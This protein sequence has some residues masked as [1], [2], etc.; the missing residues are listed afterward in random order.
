M[1][2]RKLAYLLLEAAMVVSFAHCQTATGVNYNN[3]VPAA[4]S[5]ARN[6][7]WQH[8]S[9]SPTVN[10]S[11]YMTDMLGDTGSGGADG[12][13][14]APTSGD[15]AA[16]DYLDA[17]GNWTV[18]PG[19]GGVV[20]GTAIP[21]CTKSG[22]N[23]YVYECDTSPTFTPVAGTMILFTVQDTSGSS[24]TLNVNGNGNQNFYAVGAAISAGEILDQT[25]LLIAY[26][27]INSW[28]ILSPP[29]ILPT[30]GGGTSTNGLVTAN[31]FLGGPTSGYAANVTFR[32]L[33]AAD[34]P[35]LNQSTTGNAA[36]ATALA[37]S[38]TNCSTGY[39]P[40]GINASGTAQGCAA[41]GGGGTGTVTSVAI[42]PPSIISASGSPIT[43]SGTI[44]ETL[45]TQSA[46]IVLAGPSSGS[47]ATPTFRAL[48]SAD[49]PTLNQS[50]TGN[51]ATA[52]A[53]AS[54]P[55]NCSTG[56]APTG[57]NASGTA[58]GCAALN[59]FAPIATVGPTTYT[60][61][62]GVT[63]TTF[64]T[65][66]NDG[67]QHVYMCLDQGET[68]TA[69]TAGSWQV[70]VYGTVNGTSTQVTNYTTN[71]W[72]ATLAK[73]VAL[74]LTGNSN[75]FIADPNT[76]LQ[77]RVYAASIT[78]SP[79]IVYSFTLYMIR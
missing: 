69:A 12:L 73:G 37:S 46:N 74:S 32:A 2:R 50:T 3:T 79:E 7:L 14:P 38:P 64:Y 54:S 70:V 4:P 67:V 42:T 8:D 65:T 78:G 31:K 26:D 40:T 41:L 15:W 76:V 66:P 20:A 53:L 36:T 28:N 34:V 35:T 77:Y 21:I 56:Q 13:V 11:A 17:G 30:I 19:T 18:P 60:G 39:A 22:G 51:A 59:P 72:T 61:T 75:T 43:T 5:D 57:I 33:V 52:T 27:G 49:V 55:T 47:A 16:G 48:V 24:P 29:S 63:T 62:A 58:Q 9:G 68:I 25:T 10:A 44:T 1:M 45:N 23:G 6:I 71:Q